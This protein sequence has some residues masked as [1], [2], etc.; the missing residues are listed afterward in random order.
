MYRRL[1]ALLLLTAGCAA[2][3]QPVAPETDPEPVRY[4]LPQLKQ[5]AIEQ[6]FD[7]ELMFSLRRAAEEARTGRFLLQIPSVIVEAEHE[8]DPHRRSEMFRETLRRTA[9]LCFLLDCDRRGRDLATFYRKSQRSI[10]AG[11][12]SEILAALDLHKTGTDDK[13]SGRDGM[14]LRHLCG[15]RLGEDID[16]STLPQPA[17]LPDT[18]ALVY[19][20]AGNRPECAIKYHPAALTDAVRAKFGGGDSA[21]LK[22]AEALLRNCLYIRNLSEPAL[23]Y[24]IAALVAFTVE[25]DA[26]EAET[27]RAHFQ[28]VRGTGEEADALFRWRCDYFALLED[29]G[30]EDGDIPANLKPPPARDGELPPP[31]RELLNLL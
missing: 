29:A 21:P 18:A 25:T 12:V 4:G 11:R 3:N 22:F 7:A 23:R 28:T 14:E 6:Q 8:S 30:L 13:L 20:A 24:G 26:A 5:L 1:I 27:S 19:F 2:Q 17:A 10:I 9:A 16:F 15:E 31:A